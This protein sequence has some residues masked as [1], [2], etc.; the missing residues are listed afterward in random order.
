M[1]PLKQSLKR[2]VA[3]RQV[4]GTSKSMLKGLVAFREVGGTPKAKII[5]VGGF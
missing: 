5:R 4:G 2:L 1:V 3:F